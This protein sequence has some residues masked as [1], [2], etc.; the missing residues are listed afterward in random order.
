MSSSS[1]S[2][3]TDVD[4]DANGVF[5]YILIKVTAKDGVSKMIVRGYSWVQ[6]HGISKF[7]LCIR[8]V[9]RTIWDS[10]MLEVL[11]FL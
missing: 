2:R 3:I 7:Y 11:R 10:V 5:K 4:I 6:F 8:H 9:N 1:L